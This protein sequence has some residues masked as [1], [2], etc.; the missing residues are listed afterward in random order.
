MC[1]NAKPIR[2]HARTPSDAARWPHIENPRKF[3]RPDECLDR[4]EKQIR[5][6]GRL[7]ARFRPD[8][9]NPF[10][11]VC[12]DLGSAA[13]HVRGVQVQPWTVYAS[14]VTN[15]LAFLVR[16]MRAVADATPAP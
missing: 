5:E 8:E 3:D 9:S 6:A 14:E 12:T 10:K 11:L 7:Y 15:F 13:V 2:N 1:N 16:G 4:W